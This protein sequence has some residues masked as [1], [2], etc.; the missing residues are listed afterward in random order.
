[1]KRTYKFPKLAEWLYNDEANSFTWRESAEQG[2]RL[3]L[4]FSNGRHWECDII[5]EDNSLASLNQY[6]TRARD[7]LAALRRDSDFN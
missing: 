1:M 5:H 7:A 4:I 6:F 3:Y 2:G